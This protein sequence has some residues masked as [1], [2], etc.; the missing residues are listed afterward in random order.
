MEKVGSGSNSLGTS[1]SDIEL[2]RSKNFLNP[3]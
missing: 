2:L 3:L 1:D